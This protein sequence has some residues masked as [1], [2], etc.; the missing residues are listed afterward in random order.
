MSETHDSPD[1]NRNGLD[2]ETTI[3]RNPRGDSA[4][5]GDTP[6]TGTGSGSPTP[7]RSR[8]WWTRTTTRTANSLIS[9]RWVRAL[10]RVVMSAAGSLPGI[11]RLIPPAEPAEPGQE[12]GGVGSSVLFENDRVRIW[13]MRLAPG[14]HSDLHRHELEYIIVQIA[15]DRVGADIEPGSED[16]FGLAGKRFSSTVRPGRALYVPPGGL[17]RAVN[18]G[19]REYYEVLIEL[20][21]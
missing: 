1:A 19:K 14:E 2:G 5:R 3:E 9:R 11:S 16:A 15:G 18:V 10:V 6:L 13:E 4:M 21:D 8:G 12:L 7:G 17:E 20:K